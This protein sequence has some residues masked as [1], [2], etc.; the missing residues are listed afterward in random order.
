[1]EDAPD[2]DH[3]VRSQDAN[4]RI[5]A[6]FREVI[7]A[8]HRVVVAVPDIVYTGLE[9][10][11][12]VQSRFIPD[13]PIHAANDAA[14]RIA[15]TGVAAGQLFEGIEHPALVEPAIAKIGLRVDLYLQLAGL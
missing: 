10:N 7:G 5:S 11:H 4:H 9:F 14:E 3:R 1:M 6:K 12:V 15:S 13:H 8:D 2:D